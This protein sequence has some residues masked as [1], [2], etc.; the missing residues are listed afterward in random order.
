[1]NDFE[2]VKN[3][4]IQ[5]VKEKT[6]GFDDDSWEADYKLNWEAELSERLR[7]LFSI[8]LKWPP[9]ERVGMMSC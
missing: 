3:L 6:G 2:S 9:P 4:I 5:L 1:M 7:K 8:C